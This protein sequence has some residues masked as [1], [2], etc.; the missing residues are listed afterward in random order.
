MTLSTFL[1]QDVQHAERSIP[2][3]PA[4]PSPRRIRHH[5]E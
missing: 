2:A 5:A 3:S 4:T 1:S